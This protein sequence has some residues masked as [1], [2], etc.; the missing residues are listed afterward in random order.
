L[1]SGLAA[2]SD[3]SSSSAAIAALTEAEAAASA[4]PTDLGPIELSADDLAEVDA[5]IRS[6][7]GAPELEAGERFDC[8]AALL[9]EITDELAAAD[10]AISAARAAG[11]SDAELTPLYERFHGLRHHIVLDLADESEAAEME[12]LAALRTTPLEPS[13]ADEM[14]DE[15]MLEPSH[16]D[17]M[18]VRMEVPTEEGGAR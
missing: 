12:D 11:A 9:R 1:W 8:R 13:S 10:P 5:R 3:A 14:V 6:E 2:C 15:M 16:R 4:S 17:E 18:L 7:C